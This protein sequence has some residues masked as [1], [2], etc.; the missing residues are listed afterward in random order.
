MVVSVITEEEKAFSSLL[1]RGVIYFNNMVKEL[2]EEGSNKIPGIRAF[3]LYD[4]LGFP[5]D[6]TQIMATEASMIVDIEEFELSMKQ[7]KER[8][9]QDTRNKRLGGRVPLALGAEQTAFLANQMQ[10]LPTNDAMKYSWDV[11][12]PT[13]L[14][15]IYTDKGF[16]EEIN[17]SDQDI[18]SSMVVGIILESSPFYAEA[19]GQCPDTGEIIITCNDGNVIELDV[20]DVQTYGGYLLHT[21]ALVDESKSL[22]GL[23]LHKSSS[24]I[25]KVDYTRRRKV[26]PNHTMTHVLNYALREVLGNEVEQK[27][28]SVNDEKF[29]FDF[30]WNKVMSTDELKKVESIVNEVIKSNMEVSTEVVSLQDAMT[31]SG[32]RAVFGETYPD[33]VRVV[34]IGQKVSDLLSDP[35]K[36]TWME[37]SI[38]FCGGTH[39]TRTI[40]A[41]AFVIVDETA[42]AKG[43]RRVSGVT[44]TVNY[45]LMKNA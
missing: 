36:S 10:V 5:I 2:K 1:E 6:L 31:I 25:A 39:I 30:S 4:T 35:K 28:S 29:R 33:P 43:I 21:C 42:V 15:G 7:Q 23:S 41:E 34:S 37:H 13:K 22:N 27:G 45:E 11:E 44:G 40:E 3:Y 9:R 14:N 38:E 16:V 26:A 8:S 19:G 12:I 17:N 18:S 32:L 20:L 24:V